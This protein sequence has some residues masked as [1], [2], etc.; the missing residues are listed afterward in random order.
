MGRQLAMSATLPQPNSGFFF[1]FFA[2][3]LVPSDREPGK[4]GD[5][6]LVTAL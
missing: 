1:F 4:L 2:R 5:P 3:V 6:E